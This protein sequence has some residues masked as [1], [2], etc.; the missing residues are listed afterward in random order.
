V[1]PQCGDAGV[2]V[3]QNELAFVPSAQ[4]TGSSRPMF[5]EIKIKNPAASTA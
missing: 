2:G 3:G 1:A 4:T 5:Y